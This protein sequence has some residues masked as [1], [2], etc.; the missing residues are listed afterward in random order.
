MPQ[1]YELTV[2]HVEDDVMRTRTPSDHEVL[3]DSSAEPGGAAATPVEMLLASIGA[4]SLMDV[5][6]ILDKK[7]LDYSDLKVRV[8]G[9]RRDEHPRY[10]TGVTLSYEV[11]GEVPDKA[12]EQACQL[13]VEKYCSVLATVRAAPPVSWEASVR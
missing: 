6:M 7:R 9:Q 3:F 12:M 11:E 8:V 13:S 1:P 4:C 10:F 5:A 2:E